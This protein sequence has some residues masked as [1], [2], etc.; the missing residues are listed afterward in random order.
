MTKKIEKVG[1]IGAGVMGATIAAHMANAGMDTVLLDIVPPELTEEDKKK[2]LTPESREFRNKLSNK[3][4]EN[5]LKS[6]PASFYLPEYARLIRTGNM[7]DDLETLKHVDWIIEAVV[8]RLDIKRAVFEKIEPL[9]DPE[10]IITSNTSGISAAAMSEGRSE[11]FKRRFAVTHFFNPPRYMKL[12]ELVPGPGT[13]PEAIEALDETA[14]RVLGKGVV[15]AKDTPNFIANRIGV[16]GILSVIRTMMDLGLSIEAVDQLTGPV[17]GHPKSASFRTA[18]LVGLDTLVHVAR[19]VYEGA[20]EDERR[21]V[22]QPPDLI[23]KMLEGNLLGEKA[24]QGF[25]KVSKDEKGGKAILSLDYETMQYKPQEEV[26]L[27]GLEMARNTP[28]TSARIK[29]LFYAD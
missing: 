24:K 9:L 28:G 26:R 3:G 21:D 12:L 8:E 15:K 25:Y 6:R 18:D 14:D 13:E 19:N 27:A 17:I 22:F 4:L 5:A 1:V 2:G 11:V 16:F 20:P 23:N 7:E 10:K 29:A